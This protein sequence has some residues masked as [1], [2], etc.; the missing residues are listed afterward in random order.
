MQHGAKN[1]FM[2][3]HTKE[4][5]VPLNKGT[6]FPCYSSN[7]TA[8]VSLAGTTQETTQETFCI[9]LILFFLIFTKK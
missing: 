9:Y 4:Y 5:D 8:K 3:S 2:S 1:S 6:H 7:A